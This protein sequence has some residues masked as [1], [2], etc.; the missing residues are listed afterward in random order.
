M[1]KK[2]RNRKPEKSV[3]LFVELRGGR[4]NLDLSA[5]SKGTL[6]PVIGPFIA[7]RI[8]RDEVRVTTTEREFPL[9]RIA[10][11]I[12]YD[13]SYYPDLEIVTAEKMGPARTRRQRQFVPALATL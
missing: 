9:Q 7:A 6:G 1:T 8:I 5:Y 12:F 4:A 3:G 10:D 2:L 11:W 13:G